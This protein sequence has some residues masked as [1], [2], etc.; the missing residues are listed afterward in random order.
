MYNR[1]AALSCTLLLLASCGRDA[2]VTQPPPPE[3]PVAVTASPEP[4]VTPTPVEVTPPEGLAGEIAGLWSKIDGSTLL[5]KLLMNGKEPMHPPSEWLA[6]SMGALVEVVSGYYNARDAIGYSMFYYVNN[7]YGNSRFKL[8]GADGVKPSRET[9]ERGE[10]P[11]EDYY[12]AVMRKDAP[13]DS[14][15]R[16]LVDWLLTDGGQTVAAQAGYI[17]LRPLENVFLDKAIDPVYLM[18][19]RR[20]ARHVCDRTGRT[21]APSQFLG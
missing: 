3:T 2:E 20:R 5:T 7:M 8:L 1:L 15:A 16:K 19:S 14:P 6:A 18:A 10:Y 13:A 9:I 12:Y 21:E 17:P 4:S 11:L